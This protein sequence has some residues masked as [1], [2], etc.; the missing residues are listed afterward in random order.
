[1]KG[2]FYGGGGRAGFKGEV[3]KEESGER[4]GRER[5]GFFKGVVYQRVIKG[6]VHQQGFINRGS[7]TGVYQQVV[8]KGVYKRVL[9]EK[10]L[11][12]FKKE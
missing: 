6:W 8:V 3:F 12:R 7:S 9:G 4:G 11:K 1:M 2:S 5:R 10:G